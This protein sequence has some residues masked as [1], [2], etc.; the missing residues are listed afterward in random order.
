MMKFT[1]ETLLRKGEGG[2]AEY[3]IPGIVEH[4]GEAVMC[5]EARSLCTNDWGRI[6]IMIMGEEGL[7]HLFVQQGMPASRGVT[8]AICRGDTLNNPTLISD[9]DMLHLIFHVNYFN[10]LYTRSADGGRTWAELREITGAYREFGFDWN[11]SATGPG[12]G[13]RMDNGRLVAPIWLANGE[14]EPGEIYAVKHWPSVA[15]AVY[16]DDGGDTWH[17]GALFT[18]GGD[19]MDCNE[20]TCAQLPDGSVLFNIR[21]RGE[22]RRRA[23]AVSVDGGQSSVWMQID[24]TLEDPMCFGAMIAGGGEVYFTN[25]QTMQ[26][27]VNLG[28]KRLSE[29]AWE[30]CGKIDDI[31]GYSDCAIVNGKLW[32]F[33]EHTEPSRGIPEILLAKEI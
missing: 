22:I 20:T 29:G 6:D 12:H 14:V 18:D 1:H 2:Y 17:A 23:L 9:G 30:V 27:R 31:G 16:S 24:D 15:G 19:I 4:R 26:G 33:Y 32:V 5:V 7:R 13:I 25:C 8:P 10:V 11:V 21:H 3:R 28:V